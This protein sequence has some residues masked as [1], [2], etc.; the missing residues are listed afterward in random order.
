[1]TDSKQTTLDN[2][3]KAAHTNPG[4]TSRIPLLRTGIAGFDEI[5][6]GGLPEGSLYLIQG[7]AGSGKTTLAC[8]IGF[9][10]AGAG[11]KVMVLTLIAESHAKMLNHVSNFDFFDEQLV[12]SNILLLSGYGSLASEG[13]RGLLKLITAELNRHRPHLLVIDGFRS[14]RETG[15]SDLNLSEFMHALNSL[16]FTMN[17]TTILLSPVEGNLPESENTLVD[18]VIEL[19]QYEQGMQLVREIKV[20]KVRG[21]NHLLGKHVFEING[22]GLQIFPRLEAVATRQRKVPGP[23]D[24]LVSVGIPSWDRCIGGGVVGGSITCLLGSPGVGKTLMGLH[25]IEQGLKQGEKCLIVGFSESPQRLVVKARRAGIELEPYLADGS[26][27]MLWQLPLEMLCDDLA[28][29]MLDDIAQRGVARLLIDGIDGMRSIVVQPQRGV[30]FVVALSNELRTY[31][32]TTFMTEQLAYFHDDHPPTERFAS[33]LYEN[34]MLLEYTLQDQVN[35]RQISV[36]KLRENGYD[37][38]KRLMNISDTGI[39]I[40]GPVGGHIVLGPAGR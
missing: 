23:V 28:K 22:G 17:C 29:R 13:L 36:L 40:D 30:S 25:F 6:G 4:R 34:I 2:D 31:G 37:G 26:L 15:P 1:M 33:Q 7:L 8:Q 18:G 19:S 16:V 10:Q 21:A 38:A 5:L 9:M 12:G 32:V 39:E 35:R 24:T 3:G 27:G 20:F 14:V 11:R